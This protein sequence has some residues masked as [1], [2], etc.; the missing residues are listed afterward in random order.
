[1]G[2]TFHRQVDLDACSERPF[3]LLRR[4]PQRAARR[5]QG[6]VVTGRGEASLDAEDVPR[7]I[8]VQEKAAC[9]RTEKVLPMRLDQ[10]VTYAPGLYS[11]VGQALPPAKRCAAAPEP[12]RNP[13]APR[14]GR[15]TIYNRK[16]EKE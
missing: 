5:R 2:N 4:F 15:P 12:P 11:R 16:L 13:A 14:T 10:T 7:T 3:P 6:R 9:R 8:A 1:M